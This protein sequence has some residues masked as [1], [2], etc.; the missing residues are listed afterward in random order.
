MCVTDRHFHCIIVDQS[1]QPILAGLGQVPALLTNLMQKCHCQTYQF[2]TP[3]H[4]SIAYLY[5]SLCSLSKTSSCL[6][7]TSRVKVSSDECTSSLCQGIF[8]ILYLCISLSSLS[9]QH[10]TCWC[11]VQ[12][13]SYDAFTFRLGMS[14]CVECTSSLNQDIFPIIYLWISLS[15]LFLL[16]NTFWCSIRVGSNLS[17]TSRVEFSCSV[18][19]LVYYKKTIIY[20]Y[21]SAGSLSKTGS[22]LAY[23]FWVG[24]A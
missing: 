8:S 22:C 3:S 11:S 12:A 19:K 23:T 13:C 20:L 6:A 15:S 1:K 4:F 14:A 21:N 24:N 10:N 5:I 2:I 18:K 17:C 9:L 7:Y 16:C